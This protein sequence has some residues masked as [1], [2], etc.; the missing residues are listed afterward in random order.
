MSSRIQVELGRFCILKATCLMEKRPK[1]LV[2]SE[3]VSLV[4]EFKPHIQREKNR[5]TS[6]YATTA[7][8]RI[9]PNP[10]ILTKSCELWFSID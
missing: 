8:T 1:G 10:V 3:T 4:H 9:S 2:C 7:A 6:R 5:Y